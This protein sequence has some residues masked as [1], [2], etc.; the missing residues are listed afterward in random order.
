LHVHRHSRSSLDGVRL[1]GVVLPPSVE[2][3]P[4]DSGDDQHSSLNSSKFTTSEISLI[5][6][7][8][9]S[10]GFPSVL[11]GLKPI[12]SSLVV[13]FSKSNDSL[14]SDSLSKA[15]RLIYHAVSSIATC[16]FFQ[17]KTLFQRYNCFCFACSGNFYKIP[18]TTIRSQRQI[19]DF[20]KLQQ[21]KFQSNQKKQS[22]DPKESNCR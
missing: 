5:F 1:T 10:L 3:E 20:I 19:Q 9:P 12:A 17:F 21:D 22:W 2:Y 8:I 11:I 18:Q 15:G 7:F 13:Q 14:I 4:D 16:M 6:E